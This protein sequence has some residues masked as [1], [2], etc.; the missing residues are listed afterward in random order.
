MTKEGTIKDRFEA[1]RKRA[2][3]STGVDTVQRATPSRFRV[4]QAAT[5]QDNE[6]SAQFNVTNSKIHQILTDSSLE[7]SEKIAQVSEMMLLDFENP[8][9]EKSPLSE[10]QKKVADEV[11][12]VIKKLVADYNEHNRECIRL[13]RDNPLSEL[14]K[15]MQDVMDNYHKVVKGRQDLKGKIDNVEGIIAAVGG[16]KELVHAIVNAKDMQIEKGALQDSLS[17][18]QA[19]VSGLNSEIRQLEIR[20]SRLSKSVEAGDKAWVLF[21]ESK[22]QY[23]A[24]KKELT[25]VKDS[26]VSKREALETQSTSLSEATTAYEEFVG[27]DSYKVHEQILEIL[28]IGDENFKRDLTALAEATL[29]YVDDTEDTLTQIHDQLEVILKRTDDGLTVNSNIGDKVEILRQALEQSTK[30]NIEGLDAFKKKAGAPEVEGLEGLSGL[31]EREAKKL[32]QA[33]HSYITDMDGVHVTTTTLSDQLQKLNV[34]LINMRELVDQGR[35]RAQTQQVVAITTATAS[36]KNMLDGAQA[37]A[38]L[39]QSLV[40]EGQYQ[41]EAEEAFGDAMKVME[42]SLLARESRVSAIDRMASLTQEM[43][44]AMDTSNDAT[45]AI[46]MAEK[47]QLDRLTDAMEELKQTAERKVGMSAEVIEARTEQQ[48]NAGPATPKNG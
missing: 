41:A 34:S 39:V 6:T 22:R 7:D 21:G 18:K 26:L 13:T 42:R 9:G 35:T 4:G 12:T 43:S 33:A 46:A 8:E 45:L 36:G 48:L 11:R 10:E 29:Q 2:M 23:R 1:I 15:S 5:E 24:D 32:E 20:E 38:A 44:A 37:L 25:E 31:G 3:T 28:D 30:K 16:E 47:D 19:T 14:K 27:K 40:N 17:E